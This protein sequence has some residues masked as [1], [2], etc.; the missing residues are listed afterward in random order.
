MTRIFFFFLL[1]SF[2]LVLYTRLSRI[3]P[4]QISTFVWWNSHLLCF[5]K[6]TFFFSMVFQRSWFCCARSWYY[7]SLVKIS[8]TQLP[9]ILS[10]CK[11]VTKAV[12][13]KQKIH[14]RSDTLPFFCWFNM[15]LWAVSFLELGFHFFICKLKLTEAVL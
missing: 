1:V 14:S 6:C 7:R 8:V 9:K 15:Q 12:R 4:Q 5:P 10:E 2:S 11:V 3:E 13:D